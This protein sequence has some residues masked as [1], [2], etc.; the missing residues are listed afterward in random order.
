MARTYETIILHC[1]ATP[2]SM[3]IGAMVIDKMHRARGWSQCGYHYV[4]RRNGKV[5]RGRHISLQG[6][7][8]KGHNAY[9]IGCV[10]IGGIDENGKPEDNITDKQ[11][12]SFVK[13]V[14]NLRR[15]FGTLNV[16]GHRDLP[17]VAKACPSFDTVTKF[18]K[19]F[20]DGQG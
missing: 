5:E 12:Q 18:G 11:R 20:C 9:S 13:L 10:Y 2:P 15:V 1:S 16:I 6:A 8:A 3:D 7:H 14:S 19:G 17:N 4:I